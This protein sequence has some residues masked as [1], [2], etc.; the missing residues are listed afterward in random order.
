MADFSVALTVP[1][2]K[3][4]ELLDAINWTDPP[5]DGNG[6]PL[7]DRNA[8]ESKAWFK[9]RAEN[10]LKDIFKRHKEFLRDQQA[11]SDQIDIT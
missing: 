6:D 10:A 1:D 2:D 4:Q 5:V 9:E 8:T 7:P 3:V 11:I